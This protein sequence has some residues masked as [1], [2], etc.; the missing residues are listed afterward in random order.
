MKISPYQRVKCKDDVTNVIFEIHSGNENKI[1]G[2]VKQIATSNK[3][4]AVVGV[5]QEVI[6]YY[7]SQNFFHY[8]NGQESE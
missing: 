8:L 2:I 6:A 1:F 7:L 5:G 3:N 4:T